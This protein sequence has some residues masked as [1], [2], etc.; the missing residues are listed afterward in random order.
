MS[1]LAFTCVVAVLLVAS[2]QSQ[3]ALFSGEPKKFEMLSVSDG[4]LND[5]L[6]K[7][8]GNMRGSWVIGGNGVGMN[9][10]NICRVGIS[11]I[12]ATNV[13]FTRG[14]CTKMYCKH[15][16]SLEN[17]ALK[18]LSQTCSYTF[19]GQILTIKSANGQQITLKQL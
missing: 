12:T 9:V 8:K 6:Q 18:T 3:Q 4:Q 7:V 13:T 19:N 2:I 16:M 5:T 1:R 15:T 10:C 17:F 14:P 11:N